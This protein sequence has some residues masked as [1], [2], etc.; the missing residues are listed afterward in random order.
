MERGKEEKEGLGEEGRCPWFHYV[1][2]CG[3]EHRCVMSME[4]TY[5]EHTGYRTVEGK[6]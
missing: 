3:L 4:M 5:R 1:I 6:L 2:K